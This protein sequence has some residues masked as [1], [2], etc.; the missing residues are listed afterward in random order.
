LIL[1]MVLMA[2]TL[3]IAAPS[4]R[5]FASSRQS[6][7][8]ASRLVAMTQWA[9][10]QAVAQGQVCRLNVAQDGGVAWLTVQKTGAFVEPDGDWRKGLNMP[11]GAALS[12]RTESSAGPQAPQQLAAYVQFYPTGRCDVATITLTANGETFQVVCDSPAETF[13]V[14][15]GKEAGRR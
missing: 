5:G 9:R 1:V 15:T 3:A 14:L 12:L 11:D 4:L 13:H 6:A 7:D 10:S 2:V 8:L